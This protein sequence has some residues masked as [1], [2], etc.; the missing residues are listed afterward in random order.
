MPWK[1]AMISAHD[2]TKIVLGDFML[3]WVRKMSILP[4]MEK[5]SLHNFKDNGLQLTQ[6]AVSRNMIK[7]LSFYPHKDIHTS[8]WTS[9]DGLTFKQ[10][11]HLLTDRRHK[12]NLM[13]VRSFP[14]TN[15]DSDHYLVIAHLRARI[16]HVK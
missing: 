3:R 6:L 10:I 2:M 12:S 15:N 7:G 13:D 16:S 4:Q 9:P 14:D 11:N 1:Q 5:Y 8:T